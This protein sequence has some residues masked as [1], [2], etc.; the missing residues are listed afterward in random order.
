MQILRDQSS[1]QLK[2]LTLKP[3]IDVRW[4][5]LYESCKRDHELQHPLQRVYDKESPLYL[6]T[7]DTKKNIE[8][9]CPTTS[10]YELIG[11]FLGMS[12]PYKRM[13][14]RLYVIK[15]FIYK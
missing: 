14:E 13:F 6:G 8:K 4:L 9:L 5:S 12:S 11:E 1:Q 15:L 2:P 7:S 10:Q 3:Q